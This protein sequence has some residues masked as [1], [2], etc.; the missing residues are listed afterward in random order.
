MSR[1]AE[2]VIRWYRS[3]PC[4]GQ[5]VRPVKE[6]FVDRIE[7]AWALIRGAGGIHQADKSTAARHVYYAG[8]SKTWITMER[9]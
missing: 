4:M 7:G 8:K 5:V 2:Y 3:C 9:A 1:R 6:E